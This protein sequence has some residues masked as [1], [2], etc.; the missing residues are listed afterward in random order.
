MML[1]GRDVL[2][3]VEDAQVLVEG[4]VDKPGVGLAPVVVGD[5]VRGA[6]LAGQEPVPEWG[7]R[8]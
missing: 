6:D 2:H 7:S 4:V 5:V 1:L 3:I 8:G